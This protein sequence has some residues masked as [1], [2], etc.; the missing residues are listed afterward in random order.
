[1]EK[2]FEINYRRLA[3]LLLPTFLRKEA[4]LA[5]LR[6]MG[7]PVVTLYNLFLTHRTNNL[8]RLRMNGQVCYLRRLLNDAFPEAG[9]AIRIEDGAAVGRWQYA[10]DAE[11]DPY[12]KYLLIGPLTPEGGTVFWDKSTILEGVSGFTVVVPR[13]VRTVNNDAKLRSLLNA[14]KLL[15]KSYTINYE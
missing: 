7:S 4:L 11:Y 14:Y 12:L 10:W 15:S 1:M 9:G 2:I 8:Y 5:F 3:A 6:A 13:A